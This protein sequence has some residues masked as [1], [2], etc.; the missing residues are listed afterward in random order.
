MDCLSLMCE[1]FRN[2]KSPIP[3]DA[4]ANTKQDK[5]RSPSPFI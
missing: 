5:R 2:D 4:L 3:A 1:L